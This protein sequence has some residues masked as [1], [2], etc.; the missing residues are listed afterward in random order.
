MQTA[1]PIGTTSLD[2]FCAQ[3]RKVALAFSG[4]CDSSYLLSALM[5][6]GVQVKAYLV[7]SAFLY[8]FERIDALRLASELEADVEVIE[9]DILSQ[10]EV[11]TNAHDRCYSCKSVIFGTIKNHM[12]RDGFEVLVDG[13]NADDSPERRPGFRALAKLGIL[14]PLRLAG[15][16]K[17]EVRNASRKRSLFTWDKPNFSC[18]ATKIEQG[19]PITAARLSEV[20]KR[21][22]YEDG[23]T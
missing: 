14:S 15:L 7:V 20:L 11:C 2:E 4:G 6:R 22:G 16:S 8:P 19:T 21:E 3:H 5:D 9:V 1:F 13:T 12:A 23:T 18:L 10:E 17:E